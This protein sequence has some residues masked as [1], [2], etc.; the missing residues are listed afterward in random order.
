M[1][2]GRHAGSR[3]HHRASTVDRTLRSVGRD[4]HGMICEREH[5]PSPRTFIPGFSTA[6]R[7]SA[8]TI[9]NTSS[10]FRP[11]ASFVRHPVRRSAIGFMNSTRPC[12]SVALRQTKAQSRH[13]H[14]LTKQAPREDFF[15]STSSNPARAQLLRHSSAHEIANTFGGA[16]DRAIHKRFTYAS[17]CIA[18]R[19]QG[20]RHRAD[21]LLACLVAPGPPQDHP[22]TSYEPSMRSQHRKESILGVGPNVRG[23]GSVFADHVNAHRFNEG[24]RAASSLIA[25][26]SCCP[27]RQ[28]PDQF[29]GRS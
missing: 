12:T 20:H 29:R 18:G 3:A 22:C 10:H 1:F 27:L 14:I 21:H 2:F 15:A 16:V 23:D 11:E 13:F 5:V 7:V 8:F 6:R 4:Q 19:L 26:L 24:K 28:S 25:R 9:R 17:T